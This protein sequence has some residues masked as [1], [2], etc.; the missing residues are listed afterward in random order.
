MVYVTSFA[1]MFPF[2]S[3]DGGIYDAAG[4]AIKRRLFFIFVYT[5]GNSKNRQTDGQQTHQ[6]LSGVWA[7]RPFLLGGWGSGLKEE[8]F[9][10]WSASLLH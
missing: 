10:C 1:A 6:G 4:K 3:S 8:K 2:W 5:Y 7:V 9:H